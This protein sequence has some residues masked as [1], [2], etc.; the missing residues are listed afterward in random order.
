MFEFIRERKKL[1]LVLLL[2]L[3]IPPFV[4]VGAWD[5]INPATGTIVASINGNDI[6]QRQ[7]E[8]AHQ[9][10]VEQF[11]E[12][13]GQ[14]IPPEVFNSQS[15]KEVTLDDMINREILQIVTIDQNISVP[16]EAVMSVISSIPQ[17]QTN[18]KFDLEKAQKYLKQSGTKSEIFEAS[19]RNDLALRTIPAAISDT[20]FIPRSV[21][22]KIAQAENEQRKIRV[23]FFSSLIFDSNTSVSQEEVQNFYNLN[24]DMFQ[25]PARYDLE[26]I[27]IK[28]SDQIEEIANS[29]YEESD[30]LNP[31]AVSF[32][33]DIYEVKGISLNQPVV[34]PSLP[35]DALKSLNNPNFRN[36]LRS[37]EVLGD[38]KNTDLIEIDSTLQIAARITNKHDSKLIEYD[39]V[40]PQIE[41]ELKLDKMSK[42]ANDAAEKWIKEY[43]AFEE[44]NKNKLLKQLSK[45]MKVSLNNSEMKLGKFKNAL[46][47]NLDDIFDHKFLIND[48]KK[49]DL[50]KNGALVVLLESSFIPQV[51]SSD[52]VDSLPVVYSNLNNIDSQVSFRNWLSDIKANMDVER[53]PSRLNSSAAISE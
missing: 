14:D 7:W 24:K 16:K 42:A 37:G 12:R 26:Y 3:V 34:E 47:E 10:L 33:L 17:F 35:E 49:I 11:K 28:E 23:K 9:E 27:L 5:R 52:V 40:K 39:V 45:S 31:T 29:V 25:I 21:A 15:A 1:L 53:Y 20:A 36:A 8:V 48:L 50:G 32:D 43:T 30:S 4:V 13:I 41:S 2:L 19:V 51:S 44:K 6:Y 46:S 38:G 18:G 22:R